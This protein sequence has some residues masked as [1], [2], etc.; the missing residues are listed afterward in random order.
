MAALDI[1]KEFEDP[2]SLIAQQVLAAL[3]FRLNL[4]LIYEEKHAEFVRNFLRTEAEVLANYAAAKNYFAWKEQQESIRDAIENLKQ[5]RRSPEIRRR[6]EDK[7]E[8]ELQS[9][10]ANISAEIKVLSDKIEKNHEELKDYEDINKVWNTKID[11]VVQDLTGEDGQPLTQTEQAAVKAE[12]KTAPPIAMVLAAIGESYQKDKETNPEKNHPEAKIF[13][14]FAE[15]ILALKAMHGMQ[16]KLKKTTKEGNIKDFKSITANNKFKAAK[17]TAEEHTKLTNVFLNG[18]K[19]KKI[20]SELDEE[21]KKLKELV[22]AQQSVNQWLKVVK[23]EKDDTPEAKHSYSQH[24]L[25]G[26]KPLNKQSS[27]QESNA[28]SPLSSEHPTNIKQE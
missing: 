12:L 13:T 23:A 19:I 28:E 14:A 17:L 4:E 3:F 18:V 21:E 20:I 2:N 10:L 9:Y 6:F 11:D 24:S 26:E 7:P 16:K 8:K 25:F 27:N 15:S 1:S 22:I 5:E